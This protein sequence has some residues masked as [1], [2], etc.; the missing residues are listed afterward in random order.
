MKKNKLNL[1]PLADLSLENQLQLRN[2]DLSCSSQ[3]SD[4]RLASLD[5]TLRG[6]Y[7]TS[8]TLPYLV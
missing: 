5:Q 4:D 7:S 6:V 2:N 3:D 8:N 1:Q